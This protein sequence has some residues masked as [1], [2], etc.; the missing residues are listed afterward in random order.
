MILNLRELASR[1]SMAL[2]GTLDM[3]SLVSGQADLR[4]KEPVKAELTARYDSGTAIVVGTMK[5][6]LGHSCSKCLKTFEER[7]QYPVAEAFTLQQSVA[8]RDEDI[9]LVQ[10]DTVDLT[11]YLNDTLLVHLPMAPVCDAACK[12]LCPVCGSDRNTGSCECAQDATD[13]RLAGLK[14]FFDN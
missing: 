6:V 11:S 4:I 14:Q 9:H 10:G 8:E 1:S 13:P 7:V 2:S 3:D 12:G 5:T